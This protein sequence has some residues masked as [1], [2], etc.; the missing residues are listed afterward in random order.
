MDAGDP[1]RVNADSRS[2]YVNAFK[3]IIVLNR[4]NVKWK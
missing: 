4:I 3:C 2:A 1:V